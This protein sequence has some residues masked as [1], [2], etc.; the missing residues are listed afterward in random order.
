MIHNLNIIKKH[1]AALYRENPKIH[2]NVCIRKSR[3]HLENVPA[4]IKG[5]YPN[6]FVIEEYSTGTP[7]KHTLTY[8]DVISGDVEILELNKKLEM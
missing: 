7:V 2:I 5:L 1:I 6:L 4:E 8:I 3:I